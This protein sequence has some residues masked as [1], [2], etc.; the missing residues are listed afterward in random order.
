MSPEDTNT[1]KS[2]EEMGISKASNHVA[3]IRENAD[4]GLDQS[5]PL[6]PAKMLEKKLRS[7]GKAGRDLPPSLNDVVEFNSG[8]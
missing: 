8:Q 6:D 5:G 3:E 1:Q 2:P 4:Y 7:P